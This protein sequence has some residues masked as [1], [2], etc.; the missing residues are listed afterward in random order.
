[1]RGEDQ[2]SLSSFWDDA[3]QFSE[4][5]LEDP[6]VKLINGDSD[7][8]LIVDDDE[9]LENGD[10]LLDAFR[11]I[12]ERNF[13]IVLVG[14]KLDPAAFLP[15]LKNL[16]PQILEVNGKSGDYLLQYHIH[17][18]DDFYDYVLCLLWYH[19]WFIERNHHRAD[20]TR[21]PCCI[22]KDQWLCIQAYKAGIGCVDD[23]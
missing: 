6:G 7:W 11:F 3:E 8:R 22:L 19:S 1:M 18:L 2:L 10:D 14:H 5:I 13:P 15:V 12:I 9:K 20:G 21:I 4:K 23:K 17:G 16:R